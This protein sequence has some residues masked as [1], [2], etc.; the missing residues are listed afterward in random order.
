M[1]STEYSYD[2]KFRVGDKVKPYHLYEHD[3]EFIIKEIL[4]DSFGSVL[5]KEKG[6]YGYGSQYCEK[7]T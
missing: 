1:E 4:T 6:G 3:P 2:K 5:L 7:V